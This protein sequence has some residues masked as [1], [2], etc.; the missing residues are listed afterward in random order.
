MATIYHVTTK[1]AWTRAQEKGFY[2]APSL[3]TEGFIH[4]SKAEQVAGVLQRYFAG[5][6]DLAK[7][8]IDTDKL[9]SPLQYD[10]SP[11]VNE[12]FPHVYGPINL[13]AVTVL[14]ETHSF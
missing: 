3:E 10:L 6:Q 13:N 8:T 4:C 5:K 12:E 1:E 7:L 9:T 11:S 2:T 14:E